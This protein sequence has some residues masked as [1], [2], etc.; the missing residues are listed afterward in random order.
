M[1]VESGDIV[2]VCNSKACVSYTKTDSGQYTG[3]D[4]VPQSPGPGVIQRPGV[5][6][7]GGRGGAA[8]RRPAGG[9]IG[10]G[11]CI[12]KCN[13]VVTVSGARQMHSR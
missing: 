13:G 6:E 1:I 7:G 12:G 5:G 10:V 4:A 8:H 9:G 2:V 3:K 11:T